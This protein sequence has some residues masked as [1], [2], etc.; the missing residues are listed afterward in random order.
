M[1]E[2]TFQP[3]G[4]VRS[5]FR[6]RYTAPIQA[7]TDSQLECVIELLPH[8]NFETALRDLSGFSHIW[9]L[10]VFHEAASWKPVIQTPRDGSKHGV[11]ATRSPHRPNP[12]GLS[13]VPLI[14]VE[15]RTLVIRGG[16]MLDGTPVLDIKPY[17]ADYDSFPN[18]QGGWTESL[19]GRR[20]TVI[21]W[22][23]G[24]FAQAEFVTAH[25]NI[26]VRD[27]V[28]RRLRLNPLPTD[29]NRV[30]HI[31]GD[32][33][34]LASRAWRVFYDLRGHE[35]HIMRIASAYPSDS[36]ANVDDDL[37]PDDAALHR[38]FIAWDRSTSA[39]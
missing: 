29:S 31:E 36:P 12:I 26:D 7:E 21:T 35:A 14:R 16:D 4:V 6:E 17:I 34:V 15:G 25:G 33:F 13:A 2:F 30:E 39:S 38:A 37:A 19:A 32:S 10:W 11:F 28:E 27:L 22:A 18:A 24:A 23:P 9:V 1:T 20:Q 5:P 8:M 3:I